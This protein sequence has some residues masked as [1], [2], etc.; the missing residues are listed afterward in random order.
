MVPRPAV[1]RERDSD[2]SAVGTAGRRTGVTLPQGKL[3]E[4]GLEEITGLFS[5]PVKP[6]PVKQHP[7]A[8]NID[9]QNSTLE[10]SE[11]MS[12]MDSSGLT[13]TQTLS[14]R[15][16]LGAPALP[17]P[18]STSPR[19]SGISGSARRSNG[20]DILSPSK[21]VQV[22]EAKNHENSAS[23]T[24][25]RVK[26]R[27]FVP[28]PEKQP[29]KEVMANGEAVSSA[30]ALALM[31]AVENS[32]ATSNEGVGKG[33]GEK[34]TNQAAERESQEHN[35]TANGE[36]NQPTRD[37]D[38]VHN[39]MGDDEMEEFLSSIENTIQDASPVQDIASRSVE[40]PKAKGAES[41]QPLHNQDLHQKPTAPQSKGRKRKSEDIEAEPT[42]MSAKKPAK[43]PRTTKADT[44]R[45]K[46][47]QKVGPSINLESSTNPAAVQASS[48]LIPPRIPGLI[49]DANTH[50]S[51]RQQTELDQII[52]KV[53]A[54]PGKLK[55]LYVLKRE[56]SRKGGADDVRSG[57]AVVKPIAYWNAEQCVHDEGGAAGL[58]L[59]ARIPLNSIK[60]ITS[61]RKQTKK[62]A[63]E[64]SSDEQD[65]NEEDWEK[66][67][68]VYRGQV[69]A[70]VKPGQTD[71]ENS[72]VVDLAFH[73]SSMLT[74]EVKDAPGFRFAKL[75]SNEFLG[76]GM[77]DL[78]PGSMKMPKNSRTMHMCFFVF[79]GRVT[80][81]I[82]AGVEEGECERFSVGKGGVF[83]VPRGNRYSIEN[84]LEKPARIFFSQASETVPRDE[85]T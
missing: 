79:K 24:P 34:W 16:S 1:R 20:I 8:N 11:E 32:K 50:L 28:S 10:V 7:G 14:A 12:G 19:K 70:W 83:Q 55:T 75:I 42:S 5:S 69:N 15:R 2:Y 85:K 13:P 38:S 40:E 46:G 33:Q 29:L 76:S 68:G 74:R 27:R 78:A 44:S 41:V 30:P 49:K 77:L 58:E 3:D 62:A 35:L 9:A 53:K 54:R 17:P 72:E 66:E 81:R 71:V 59:G 26:P 61:E 4:N 64:D 43:K 21:A 22:V 84:E 57:R 65:P 25:I 56:K 39:P 47:K 80:V 51:Q 48:Q 67:V 82:G 45:A 73:P 63:D 36:P 23:P 18:R 31:K 37:D 52:E 6:S 60:E